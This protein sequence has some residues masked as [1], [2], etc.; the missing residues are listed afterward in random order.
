MAELYDY[1]KLDC[2]KIENISIILLYL[3]GVMRDFSKAKFTLNS[4]LQSLPVFN[5]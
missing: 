2:S 4:F 5:V 1:E 3:F